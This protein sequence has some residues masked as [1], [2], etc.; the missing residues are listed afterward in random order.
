[1]Q[2]IPKDIPPFEGF[3]KELTDFLWGLSF[4][5]ERPW[6]QAHKE[7]FERC[8]HRPVQALAW[9]LRDRLE[10]HMPGLAPEVHISRIYRDARR[11][12]GRGPYNDHLWFSLG[13]TAD[14]YTSLPQYWFGIHAE[15]YNWGLGVWNMSG[16]ALERWRQ[17]IDVNPAPL[18]RIVRKVNKMDGVAFMGQTYKRPK[19]DPGKLLYD[20]YSARDIAV[21]KTG[22]F[23]PDPPGPEL[24]DEMT[25]AFCQL[26]PLYKYLMKI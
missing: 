25:E 23:D 15:S 7:E 13:V 2:A 1:M 20:W 3:P 14:L 24:L 6:F 8:L 22:W 11:L 16:E 10:E 26:A 17:A 12:Y 18:S 5:N 19:G 21:G 9:Q 4:N